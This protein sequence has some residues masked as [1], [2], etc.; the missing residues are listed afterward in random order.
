M[1]RIKIFTVLCLVLSVVIGVSS[2]KAMS[3]SQLLEKLTATYDING[4][5]FQLS[6]GDRVLAKRY[7]DLYEVSSA[8]ADYIAG[9]IDSAIKDMRDS[10]IK[11][12]S[13]FSKLPSSLK[14]K[15]KQ[16]VLNVAANTSIKATVKNGKVIVFNPDGTVFAEIGKLVKNTGSNLNIIA[17][18]ALLVT[19]VGT[20]LIVRN[21]K[22]NA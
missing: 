2:V 5:K 7:L 1:R 4:Y 10:G 12:F 16:H 19:A 13:D 8:H 9:E 14:E 21:V 20:V 11:D 6:D 22:A 18:V 3:E 17:T 15:L